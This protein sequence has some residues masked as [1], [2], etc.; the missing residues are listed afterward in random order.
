MHQHIC[1]TGECRLLPSLQESDSYTQELKASCQLAMIWNCKAH[2]VLTLLF[3][4]DL[5]G[6]SDYI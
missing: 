6:L 2:D 5:C 1:T 3:E 4:P